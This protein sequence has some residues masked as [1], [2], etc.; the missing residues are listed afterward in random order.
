[1][2]NTL[3]SLAKKYPTDKFTV[4]PYLEVYKNLFDSIRADIKN[5]LEMGVQYGY[6]FSLWNDYFFNAHICGI[7]IVDL[8]PST[9]QM[10]NRMSFHKGDAYDTTFIQKIA[11]KTFDVLIDD[12]PHTLPSMLFF[13]KHYSKLLSLGGVLIIEDIPDLNWTPQIISALPNKCVTKIINGK[14]VTGEIVVV[15][16]ECAS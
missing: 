5:V 8:R 16:Q 13:A 14:S 2:M 3:E 12:G 4:H 7:D 11:K 6:S 1:M 10:S 15:A 9:F